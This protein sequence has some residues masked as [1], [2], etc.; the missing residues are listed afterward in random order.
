MAAQVGQKFCATC[1]KVIHE[2]AEI[3]PNCGVRQ[4][5][6][7]SAGGKTKMA[8]GLLAIFLGGLGVHKFYLG[9]TGMG[10][11]Y[12][13]FSWTMIPLFIGFIEGIIYLSM[14]DADFDR[15]YNS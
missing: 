8:A 15:K 9:Q 10:V 11:I 2:K 3:C 4:P 5:G 7:I 14:N 6:V 1:G 13:L 12:L